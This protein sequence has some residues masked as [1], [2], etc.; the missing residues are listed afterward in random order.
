MRLLYDF[1]IKDFNEFKRS[2]KILLIMSVFV[3]YPMTLNIIANKPLIPI[4][5]IIMPSVVITA[6]LSGEL[7]YFL[8]INEIQYNIFDVF[9][10]S[11]M[12]R[13]KLILCRLSLP[14]VCSFL[15]ALMSMCVNNSVASH[16]VNQTYVEVQINFET[17]LTLIAI[18]TISGLIEFGIIMIFNKKLVAEKHTFTT[19]IS[20]A[21]LI[22][23]YVV[24][25]TFGI[26]TFVITSTILILSLITL[27]YCLINIY[28]RPNKIKYINFN[29]SI[30]PD[31]KLST[32][33][34]LLRKDIVISNF[35]VF[36]VLKLLIVA[37]FP[38]LINSINI[39]NIHLLKSIY[40]TSLYFVCH[41]GVANIL[42]PILSEEKINRYT[43]IFQVAKINKFKLYFSRAILPIG[44]TFLGLLFVLLITGV[45]SAMTNTIL[46]FDIGTVIISIISSILCILISFWLSRYVNSYKDIHV[47]GI[48]IMI[49]TFFIHLIICFVPYFVFLY[50]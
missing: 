17:L 46:L 3:I 13:F 42:F 33:S 20:V 22:A 44:T 9:L 28:K 47:V 39:N 1:I 49:M 48:F 14:V 4:E 31:K 5:F 34:G 45:Y 37:T 23:M 43:D 15:L 16:F 32:I 38:I 2:K 25:I 6:G 50:S 26:F 36:M 21:V 19:A 12:N 30:F 41:F 7:L 40:R 8:M 35:N 18:A 29:K 27:D 10:V 24:F 11:K